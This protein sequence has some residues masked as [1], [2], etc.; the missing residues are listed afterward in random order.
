MATIYFAFALSSLVG[1]DLSLPG[2]RVHIIQPPWA[3]GIVGASLQRIAG[4]SPPGGGAGP[5]TVP[6]SAAASPTPIEGED[7]T[8]GA[9]KEGVVRPYGCEFLAGGI[10][11]F[12]PSW[13]VVDKIT[14]G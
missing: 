1:P 9:S 5:V 13:L 7:E 2:A 14:G 8:P 11:P 3:G 12:R 6:S 4:E 10:S